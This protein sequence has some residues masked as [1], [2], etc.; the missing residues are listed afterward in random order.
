MSK[1]TKSY[2]IQARHILDFRFISLIVLAM[3][4][5]S[6]STAHAL[7]SVEIDADH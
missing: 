5:Q 1:T 3:D 2:I 4:R 7:N 6:R